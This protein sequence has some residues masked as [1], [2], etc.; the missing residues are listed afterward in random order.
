LDPRVYDVFDSKSALEFN[1]E[2]VTLTPWTPCR[3]QRH[4][5]QNWKRSSPCVLFARYC[6]GDNMKSLVPHMKQ[7]KTYVSE[8]YV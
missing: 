3:S 1:S 2:V 6:Y 8:Y 5:A 7:P 4:V